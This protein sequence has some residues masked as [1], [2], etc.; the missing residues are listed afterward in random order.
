[1]GKRGHRSINCALLSRSYACLTIVVLTDCLSRDWSLETVRTGRE[2]LGSLATARQT[3]KDRR[4][5]QTKVWLV[6]NR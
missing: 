3:I 2:M 4:E 6:G 1:M 5:R